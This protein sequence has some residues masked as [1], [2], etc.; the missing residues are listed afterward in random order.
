M[1]R[2]SDRSCSFSRMGNLF[3]MGAL[4]FHRIRSVS[5]SSPQHVMAYFSPNRRQQRYCDGT[6]NTYFAGC[7]SVI[8]KIENEDLV[9]LHSRSSAGSGTDLVSKNSG[10]G[11]SLGG[12]HVLALRNKSPAGCCGVSSSF[13]FLRTC[14]KSGPPVSRT[15]WHKPGLPRH[16]RQAA[17]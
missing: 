15:K 1:H 11:N 16:R 17:V 5:S 8:K 3:A 14:S 12:S 10:R 13:Y 6:H 7:D 4:T 2:K 9:R